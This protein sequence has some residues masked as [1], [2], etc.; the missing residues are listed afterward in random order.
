MMHYLR[1]LPGHLY[2]NLVKVYE[3]DFKLFGYEIPNLSP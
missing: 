2:D 1:E 3:I